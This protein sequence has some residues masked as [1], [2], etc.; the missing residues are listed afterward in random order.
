MNL[1]ERIDAL[2]PQTQCERCGFA[3]CRPYAEALARGESTPDRCPP[4]GRAVLA[5]L[6]TLLGRGEADEVDPT[7]GDYPGLTVARIDEARCI[8]CTLC[9][10]ACPVDAIVGASRRMHTVIADECTGCELCLPPC[11]VDCITLVPLAPAATRADSWS[12]MPA[13]WSESRAPR[14]RRRAEARRARLTREAEAR[15]AGARVAAARVARERRQAEIAA[16][17]ARARARRAGEGE[18]QS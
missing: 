17:V 10:R 4:G 5:R 18:R 12:G 6:S 3:G 11:P 13:W 14:A 8:G 2:L 15:Q 1:V 7:C 16:A 9:I